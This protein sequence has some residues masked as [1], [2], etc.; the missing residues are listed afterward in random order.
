[1]WETNSYK[2]H[3]DHMMLY[4]ALEKSMN[5]DH[6]EELLK[7]LAEA[8]K[9]KKKRRDAPKTPPESPPYQPLPPPPPAG[10]SHGSAAP[11]STKTTALA[12][13]KAWT[14]TDTRLRTS[15]SSAPEDL[16]MDD[17]MALDAQVHSSDDEDIGNAHI[18]KVNLW[19]D[20]WKP[21]E[22]DRPATPEPAWSIPSSD[23]PVPKNNW[24]SALAS[25][26]SPPLEDSLL[27]QTSDM[28]MFM[29]WFCKR[30]AIIELKPQDL[31]G[32]TFE[33]VKVFHPNVIHLKYQMEECHILLTD[34]VDDSI[35]RPALSISKIK[36][37]YYLNVG[38]E[39]MVPDQMWIEEECKYDIVA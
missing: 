19:Q 26:Y 27:A 12:E 10:Q 16:Q 28:A 20:W 22:E 31:E 17:D 5:R 23:L 13:Y 30:Q 6:T 9:K 21:L 8:R 2:T 36:A 7:D 4:E 29:D 11:S 33:L 15:V 25:T 3:E 14:T 38:L 39:Q 32:P 24:A 35:I 18:L 37:A 34:S 1:M